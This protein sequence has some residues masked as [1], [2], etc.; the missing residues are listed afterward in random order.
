MTGRAKQFSS[1][2]RV[3]PTVVSKGRKT[4]STL[5]KKKIAQS[6]KV[7]GRGGGPLKTIVTIRVSVTKN[8]IYIF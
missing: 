4:G 3:H 8:P 6:L 2:A 1:Y 5:K 7:P